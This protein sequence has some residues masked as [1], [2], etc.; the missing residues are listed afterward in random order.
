MSSCWYL[1]T[2]A[3]DFSPSLGS[4]LPSAGEDLLTQRVKE[5]VLEGSG[6]RTQDSSGDLGVMEGPPKRRNL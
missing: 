4:I 5:P 1:I 6:S 3:N 2:E